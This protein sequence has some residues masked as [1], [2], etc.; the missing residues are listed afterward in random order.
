M[1][2]SVTVPKTAVQN[3]SRARTFRLWITAGP[4]L[5]WIILFLLIPSLGLLGLGFMS[6]NDYGSPVMPLTTQAFA[7][8]CWIFD[9]GLG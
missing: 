7:A 8:G 1:S 3:E 4:G 6:S 2:A 9:A 5:F